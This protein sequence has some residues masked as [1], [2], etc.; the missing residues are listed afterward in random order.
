MKAISFLS[1]IYLL[2]GCSSSQVAVEKKSMR[3]IEEPI[4]L[5]SNHND[6]KKPL[7][8]NISISYP[9]LEGLTK[10]QAKDIREEIFKSAVSQ[11]LGAIYLLPMSGL[12]KDTSK[13]EIISEDDE[14]YCKDLIV[15]GDFLVCASKGTKNVWNPDTAKINLGSYY[16]SQR[17]GDQYLKE[18]ANK[19][20]VYLD[21]KEAPPFELLSSN[22]QNESYSLDF[23][24]TGEP[25]VEHRF[26]KRFRLAPDKFKLVTHKQT[27]AE[28]S[29]E[30]FF[31]AKKTTGKLITPIYQL[32][33]NFDNFIYQNAV[34]PSKSQLQTAQNKIID[35]FQGFDFK[36]PYG[37]PESP[38]A[39]YDGCPIHQ[40]DCGIHIGS[41]ILDAS[42]EKYIVPHMN[43]IDFTSKNQF[44]RLIQDKSYRAHILGLLMLAHTTYDLER[45]SKENVILKFKVDLGS[46]LNDYPVKPVKEF[47]E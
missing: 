26:Y 25:G 20:G 22:S 37:D 10:D 44:R 24:Y 14:L 42:T 23:K 17:Y 12:I 15:N 9:S 36:Q 43:D 40:E 8:L 13:M 19:P 47:I 21:Y 6:L 33:S 34:I 35:L 1:I 38:K 4:S 45:P 46:V 16:W 39:F 7:F 32:S 3:Q 41:F 30:F 18:C 28:L 11:S 31:I 2:A 5:I 29:L 27:N